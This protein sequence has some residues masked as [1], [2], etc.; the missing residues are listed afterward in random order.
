MF[1]KTTAAIA[2]VGLTVLLSACNEKTAAKEETLKLDNQTDKAS[3]SIGVQMGSQMSKIKDMVNKDAI[4]MGFKDSLSGKD[5]QLTP[6]DM[7]TTMQTFQ[8]AMME[9]QKVEMEKKKVE[10]EAKAAL[11][12]TE[13]EKFLTENKAKTGIT[14]TD[15]GLQYK[16]ITAGTGATPKATDTVVTHYKGTLID[17]TEFDSS[18]KR[19][20]PATFPVNGVIKGW[21][22]ALQLMKVGDKWQLFI[23]SELAY[24]DRGAGK[25]IGPGQM[26]I[27]DIELLE[28]KQPAAAKPNANADAKTTAKPNANADAKTTAKAEGNASK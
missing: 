7:R 17:G 9:M 28:I 12:K 25:D 20:A 14:T 18:Y 2:C 24:G 3:Y 1:K 5:P 22:E 16:V 10:N 8:T 13:G 26:L 15:S 21:T 6:E 11:N 4:I 27:F 19:D 23:P